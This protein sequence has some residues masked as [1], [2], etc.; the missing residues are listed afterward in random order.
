MQ[1]SF[2]YRLKGELAAVEEKKNCCRRA[3]FYGLLYAAEI[4]AEDEISV[5]FLHPAVS[6]LFGVLARDCIKRET[7]VEERVEVGRRK[8]IHTFSAKRVA[9]FLRSV[10]EPGGQ[11]VP[12]LAEFRCAECCRCFL[13]GVFLSVGTVSDPE[14]A[15]HAE[16]VMANAVRADRL[17]ELLA[18]EGFP[19][20]R[21]LRGKRIGLYYKKNEEIEE[22]FTVIGAIR[23][24]LELINLKIEKEIRNNEN[25]A[26]NCV[27]KNIS[28]T[29]DAVAKQIAAIEKLREHGVL[30]GLPEDLR[31]TGE[32]R[33]KYDEAS[34]AE[35]AAAHVPPISKSGLNHR[36]AR[37]SEMAEKLK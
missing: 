34:L 37:L 19:A 6:E 17:D 14:K 20:R 2:S 31:I 16:L 26:T 5:S 9:V 32:L 28:R 36:L 33:L 1:I 27:A 18:V 8:W 12:E 4:K 29:V 11:G 10:S 23:A 15:F 30:D 3:L 22:L 13:R 25:R 21:V 7:D 35:L 24:A